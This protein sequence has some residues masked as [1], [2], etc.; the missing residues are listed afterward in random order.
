MLTVSILKKPS[1]V[2]TIGRSR[3]VCQVHATPYGTQFFRFRIHFHQ[4]APTSE[5]HAPPMGNPGSAC[6]TARAAPESPTGC[7]YQMRQR[8]HRALCALL[9]SPGAALFTHTH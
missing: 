5:V 8:T 1:C 6:D 9:R 2:H 3:G 4:K 7:V